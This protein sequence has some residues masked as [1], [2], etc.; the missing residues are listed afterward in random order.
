MNKFLLTA[1]TIAIATAGF[2]QDNPP[3][4]LV[5]NPYFKTS[6]KIKGAGSIE[7]ADGWYG[8]T[9]DTPDLYSTKAKGEYNAEMNA[10]GG[11][12]PEG[13]DGVAGILAYS[14]KNK[15]RRSY[16]GTELKEPLEA[17]RLY[18]VK[19]HMSMADL[20]KY[21]CNGIGAYLSEEKPMPGAI[22]KDEIEPQVRHSQNK[23]FTETAMFES[24]CQVYEAQGGEKFLTIGSFGPVDGIQSLKVKRPSGFNQPQVYMG[25]YYIDAVTVSPMDSISSSA[26]SCEKVAGGGKVNV[27]YKSNVSAQA[28]LDLEKEVKIRKVYFDAASD[29]LTADAKAEIAKVAELM[30][31]HPDLRLEV[32][33]HMDKLELAEAGKTM[34][35][36]RSLA[37]YNALVAA[38]IDASRLEHGDFGTLEPATTESTPQARARNRRVDFRLLK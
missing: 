4:N 11:A 15:E 23:V 32:K 27:V 30:K 12:T 34:G 31:K 20:S 6:K 9:E 2:A 29:A 13:G 38:G 18:C 17:G 33:G 37:V 24:V 1:L 26:C 3:G 14:Y 25:Y 5:P 7:L 16:L 28:E 8:A 22:M 10:Y 19:F 36:K 35:D 21:A